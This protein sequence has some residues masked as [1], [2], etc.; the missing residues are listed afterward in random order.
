MVR[1]GQTRF[2]VECQESALSITEWMQRTRDYN[3]TGYPV[4]W[5][6]DLRRIIGAEGKAH[7]FSWVIQNWDE[8][9]ARIP[10]EVRLCHK[11]S[12]GKVYVLD[13]LGDIRSCNLQQV[14]TRF[15][16][17]GPDWDP[18]SY[19]PRTLKQPR[20]YPV[21]MKPARFFGVNGESLIALGEGVWWK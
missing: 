15:T 20:F 1:S 17:G 8:E 4:L 11:N 19:T 7:P 21:P 13:C 6:W 16:D 12:Y 9:E 2:V 10:A 5:V 18:S 14:S 3:D